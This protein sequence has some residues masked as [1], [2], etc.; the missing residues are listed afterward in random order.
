[1][2][3]PLQMCFWFAAFD[4]PFTFVPSRDHGQSGRN[5]FSPG[6]ASVF[7]GTAHQ[8]R[9][10]GFWRFDESDSRRAAEFVGAGRHEIAAAKPA[11]RFLADPL[12]RIARE[13]NSA[14]AAKIERFAPRLQNPGF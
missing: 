13:G 4:L 8:E 5:V 11:R 1:M 10:E 9:L 7:L 6:A 3:A 2:V 14:R 12:R